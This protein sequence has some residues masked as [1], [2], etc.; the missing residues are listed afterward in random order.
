[1]INFIKN[2]DN[3]RK[4]KKQRNDVQEKIIERKSSRIARK[5]KKGNDFLV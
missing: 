2:S 1:M 4:N 5:P 3:Q